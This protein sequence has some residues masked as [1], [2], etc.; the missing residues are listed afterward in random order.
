MDAPSLGLFEARWKT[1]LTNLLQWEGHGKGAF[2]PLNTSLC[3]CVPQ[4]DAANRADQYGGE[5]LPLGL[6]LHSGSARGGKK[7]ALSAFFSSRLDNESRLQPGGRGSSTATPK[8]AAAISRSRAPS[9]PLLTLPPSRYCAR[10]WRGGV[11]AC[12]SRPYIKAG[13]GGAG[14]VAL[15]MRTGGGTMARSLILGL[16]SLLGLLA[17]GK[18]CPP[19]PLPHP[20]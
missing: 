15:Q 17:A 11:R 10:A 9:R 14:G 13:A 5:L 12:A 8:A 4:S 3:W 1:A 7:M 19:E 2:Q 6:P 18:R 20:V 16:L